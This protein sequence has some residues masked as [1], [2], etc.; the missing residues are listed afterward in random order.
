MQLRELLLRAGAATLALAHG[1]D[2]D[3]AQKP[4]A[5]SEN[6]HHPAYGTHILSKS[7]LVIYL[8]GFLAA[9]ERAHLTEIT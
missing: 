6:C 2:E 9:E 3:P 8:T 7:P 5:L 4:L 1:H